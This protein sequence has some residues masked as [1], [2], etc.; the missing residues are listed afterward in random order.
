MKVVKLTKKMLAMYPD[1]LLV[2]LGAVNNSKT[3]VY[4]CHVYFSEKDYETLKNSLKKKIKKEMV[5]ATEKH[6][7][8]VVEFELLNVGP[9]EGLK[10]A[11]KPGFAIIDVES[12]RNENMD[13]ELTKSL[14][15]YKRENSEIQ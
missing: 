11:I 12:I 8:T 15:Y 4:P 9:N 5:W 2:K 1:D 10:K 14:E 13:K 7:K 3:V 6:I